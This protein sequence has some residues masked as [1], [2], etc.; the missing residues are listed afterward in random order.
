MSEPVDNLWITPNG[1]SPRRSQVN[2]TY[3]IGNRYYKPL[4]INDLQHPKY[5]KITH[6]YHGE[7][8]VNRNVARMH[9]NTQKNHQKQ[10]SSVVYVKR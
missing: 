5:W 6:L 1:L 7:N 10:A 9:H 3:I 2:I 8:S 4:K